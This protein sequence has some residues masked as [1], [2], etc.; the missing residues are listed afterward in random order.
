[1]SPYDIH[2]L[3]SLDF[4]K[5]FVRQAPNYIRP[6]A[7]NESYR[8]SDTYMLIQDIA[9]WS[10]IGYRRMCLVLSLGGHKNVRVFGMAVLR[11]MFGVVN[12]W[13]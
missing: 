3:N 10:L 1:M 13:L 7:R 11:S 2:H 9:V 5:I 6:N 12:R 4:N 8:P